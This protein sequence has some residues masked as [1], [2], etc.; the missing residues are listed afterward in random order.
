MSHWTAQASRFAG[1]GIL[2]T[3]VHVTVGYLV[4]RLAGANPFLANLTGFGVA[5]WVSYCGNFYWT[6]PGGT[7]HAFRLK[8]FIISSAFCFLLSN[9]VVATVN[10]LH[11][12]FEVALLAIVLVIPPLSFALAKFWAFRSLPAGGKSQAPP[13]ADEDQGEV[14]PS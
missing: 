3:L 9:A 2:A 1:V 5:F 4:S 11:L 6:F 10:L 13:N 8:R 12:P 7:E 14:L